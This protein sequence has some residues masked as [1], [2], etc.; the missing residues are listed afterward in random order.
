MPDPK[1]T[2]G[3]TTG[4]TILLVVAM[5]AAVLELAAGVDLAD[6]IT[7][8]TNPCTGTAQTDLIMGTN[9]PEEIRALAG[10]DM[11]YGHGGGDLVYGGDG[12]DNPLAGDGQANDA[13]DG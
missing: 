8:S 9:D 4:R 6:N 12:D 2:K 13:L 10:N 11:A 3:E 5:S 1:V 7:C